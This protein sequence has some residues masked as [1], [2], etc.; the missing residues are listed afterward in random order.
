[1]IAAA[2]KVCEPCILS[3]MQRTCLLLLC[4]LTA[5]S[6]IAQ[7]ERTF[8]SQ[9]NLVRVPTLVLDQNGAAVLGLSLADFIVED[10]GIAQTAHMD[11]GSESE[12][13]SIMIAIQCGRGAKREYGRM[14]G[15]SSMLDP[16]LSNPQNEAAIL[17]FDSKLN[18][19]RNFVSNAE[20]VEN[21][22]QK[23]PSGDGGAAILDAVAYSAKLLGQRPGDHKR[24]LLLISETRDHGSQFTKL[25]EVLKAVDGNEVSVYALPFSPYVS[26]QLDDLR[27]SNRDEWKPDIDILA[28]LEEIRQLMRKNIPQA[29]AHLTGGEY[30]RFSTQSAFENHLIDF[31]NHLHSRYELSFEPNHPHPGLHQVRVQMRDPSNDRT[32]IC[33]TTYWVSSGGK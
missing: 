21:D 2:I 22:L 11:E 6:A 26:Q 19:A 8:S 20:G 23:L 25:D 27:G 32:L 31:A 12:P 29:I 15:L 24:V 14:K 30:K 18:L 13:V 28:R 5:A 10:D 4:F 9:S 17:F 16:L 7:E 1:V 33:R 3:Y